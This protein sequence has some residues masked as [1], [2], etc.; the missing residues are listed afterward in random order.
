MTLKKNFKR[1][2][3]NKPQLKAA[4][5]Q[6]QTHVHLWGR[7]TGKTAGVAPHWILQRVYKM[8]RSTGAIV[9]HTYQS[10]LQRT[11]PSINI[12]LE[13]WGY[14]QGRDYFIGRFGPKSWKRP[15]F[16][17][18]NDPSYL[19]H[20]KN[21]SGLILSSQHGN[22]GNINGA[23]IDYGLTDEAKYL[24]KKKF[25][26]EVIPAL[27]GN[28]QAFKK[29]S[30]FGSWLFIT[31]MPSHPSANWLFEYEKLMD[32]KLIRL[33][34]SLQLKIDELKLESFKAEGTRLTR[35]N[36]LIRLYETEVNELRKDAV[37]YSEASTLENIEV[38]GLRYIKNMKK[39]L[40]EIEY[41]M[42]ILNQ[43]IHRTS[44][45]FY[46]NLD[47]TV[48]G[49]YATDNEYL[50]N[51]DYDFQRLSNLTCRKDKDLNPQQDLH[52]ALDYGNAINC[53]VTGQRY[54]DEFRLLSG[55]H[56]KD[57]LR[58][59]D[60]AKKW[61]D[62]YQDHPTKTVHYYYDH[63][64]VGRTG[65]DNL[66]YHKEWITQLQSRG[67]RVISYYIGQQPGYVTRFNFWQKLLVEPSGVYAKFRYNRQNCED[68]ETA[69][70]SAGTKDSRGRFEKNKD[71]ERNSAIPREHATDYT[72][73]TDTLVMSVIELKP[74]PD[75][76]PG[77]GGGA[78]FL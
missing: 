52:C 78:V 45:M 51:F 44:F 40:P 7:R 47:P 35:L 50:R 41:R 24:N 61:C 70:L 13:K 2:H 55:M 38:L 69:T 30:C 5:V 9:G 64:A 71:S 74:T 54:Q 75:V 72:D 36:H 27:S 21:G 57:P 65:L 34:M 66:T 26:E 18:Q 63:T 33:I 20:F 6:A 37:Y 39:T 49:Y 16:V 12:G 25:D 3:L 76:I 56:V 43:R 29:H 10:L 53:V 32:P 4:L 58:L 67:W 60:L 68:W 22:I 48:H 23:T 62:Y 19:V 8:P 46:G 1:K 59:K 31:D 73:A 17:P 15:I 77:Q 28:H 14:K 42:S 11:L